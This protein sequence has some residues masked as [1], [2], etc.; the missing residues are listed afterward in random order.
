MMIMSPSQ[1]NIAAAQGPRLR[2]I[3]MPPE[4][5]WWPP[6]PGWWLLGGV[7]LLVL[8]AAVWRWW[9]YRR[10]AA[11]CQRV[12]AEVD[13]IAAQYRL[14]RDGGALASGLHQLLR[15]AV[16]Q[17][18]GAAAQHSGMGWQQV[19]ARVPVD[20]LTLGRLLQ[21]EQAMYRPAPDFDQEHSVAAVRQWLRLA[22]EP[23]AWRRPATEQGDA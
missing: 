18:D 19:L 13:R 20:A 22:L 6:A 21:L 8:L 16:R 4:P 7:L 5:S 14:D 1:Q 15:R 9:R 2:D 12:L 11:R 23:R 3:H 17:H 10:L